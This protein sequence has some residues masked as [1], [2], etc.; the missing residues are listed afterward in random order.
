MKKMFVTLV[1]CFAAFSAFAQDAETSTTEGQVADV[2]STG[3][4]E[5]DAQ[6]ADASDNSGS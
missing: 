3:T 2:E 1:G 6:V 5:A 4:Q